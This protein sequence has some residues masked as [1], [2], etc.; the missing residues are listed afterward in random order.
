MTDTKK[1]KAKIAEK[2]LKKNFLAKACGV[3]PRTFSDKVNGKRPFVQN[4]ILVLKSLLVLSDEEITA[5]FF[6]EEV[7]NSSPIGGEN[8][9]SD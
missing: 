4:E 9:H 1:L 2:G 8:G 3:T 7:D 6:A 5:I